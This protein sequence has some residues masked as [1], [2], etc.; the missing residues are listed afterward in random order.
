MSKVYLVVRGILR[1]EV[2]FTETEESALVYSFD[3]GRNEKYSTQ[4]IFCDYKEI[5]QLF[6]FK[7]RKEAYSVK[8]S[9]DEIIRK[10]R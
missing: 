4:N 2:R 10:G 9:I 3:C 6:Y 5:S 7:T 1:D 8:R